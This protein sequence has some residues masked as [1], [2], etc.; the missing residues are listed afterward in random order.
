[1]NNRLKTFMLMAALTAFFMAIGLLIGGRAGM[2]IAFLVALGLNFFSYWS[3]DK[4]V[5]KAYGAKPVTSGPVYEFTREL[6]QRAQLPMPKSCIIESAQP[7]AFATGR[8]PENSAV[9]VSTGLMRLLN[10][11]ELR[12]VIAHELAHIK[13][14]DT[15]TMTLTATIAGAIGMLANFALFFGGARERHGLVGTLALMFLAPLAASLVQMTI[16]RVREYEADKTG[17]QISGDP[18]AL[19][20]ALAKLEQGSKA[21]RND[22]AEANPAT[23]HMFIVNPLHGERMDN[24]FSTHPAIANR[25]TALQQ[26]AQSMPGAEEG[27]PTS[28]YDDFPPDGKGPPRRRRPGPWG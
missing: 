15:L 27:P 2:M 1:M 28:G 5:L 4:I 23:A 22:K 25:I 7:N 26:L 24:L 19:A 14:R 6:A 10:E 13:N 18:L 16:S 9:V 11:R 8:N 3:S 12:G 17:A 21:K 20:S